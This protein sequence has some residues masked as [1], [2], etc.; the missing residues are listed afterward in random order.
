LPDVRFWRRVQPVAATHWLNRSAGD[1]KSSVFLGRSLSWRA[2]LFSSAWECAAMS[3][4]WGEADMAS[5]DGHTGGFVST[6]PSEPSVITKK[7]FASIFDRIRLGETDFNPENF[8]PGTSGSTKLFRVL[9]EQ[10][11]LG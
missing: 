11:R 7:Q 6:R 1:W 3:A 2:T 9:L 8:L 4:Y 5:A 10:S